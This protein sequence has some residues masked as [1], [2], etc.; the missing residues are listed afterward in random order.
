MGRRWGG[1]RGN[2]SGSGRKRGGFQ[3][4]AGRKDPDVDESVTIEVCLPRCF[5]LPEK[6][7]DPQKSMQVASKRDALLLY[8]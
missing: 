8:L 3:G 6:P 2:L 1:D 7:A 4:Q 5:N